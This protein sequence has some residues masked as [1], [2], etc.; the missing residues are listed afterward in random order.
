MSFLNYLGRLTGPSCSNRFSI[1]LPFRKSCHRDFRPLRGK[2]LSCKALNW[3]N[4]SVAANLER[5]RN[6]VADAC[7]RAHRNPSDVALMAVSKVHPAE[8]F[9]E[10][11]AAGQ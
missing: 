4:M 11:Y 1:K 7:A 9:L 2:A 5:L 3:R 8:A 10:A 6:E